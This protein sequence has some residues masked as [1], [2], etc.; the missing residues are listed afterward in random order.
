APKL[1]L[2]L[3]AEHSGADAGQFYDALWVH[4]AQVNAAFGLARVALAGGDREAAVLVLDE[5]PESS[6][7]DEAARIAGIRVLSGVLPAGA[8]RLPREADLRRAEDRLSTLDIDEQPAHRLR[9][10]VLETA[11]ACHRELAP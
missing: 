2:G 11:L 3:C 5:V 1:A 8:R 6:R 10:A 9:A 7:H 4:R